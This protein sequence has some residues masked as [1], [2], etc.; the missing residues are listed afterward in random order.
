M[1]AFTNQADECDCS[2][3]I[4]GTLILL[5]ILSLLGECISMC[6]SRKR[7]TEFETENKT[8]RNLILTTVDKTLV[9]MMK[10]G[11]NVGFE[12]D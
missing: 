9:K 10:N 7:L 12:D 5:L 11:N 4:R 2:I 6:K 3:Q 8:L 1:N